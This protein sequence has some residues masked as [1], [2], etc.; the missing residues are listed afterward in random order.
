MNFIF[1]IEQ[2][3]IENI[4]LFEKKKNV[5]IDGNFTK[6]IY[7]DDLITMNGIYLNFPIEIQNNTKHYSNKNI[8]FYPYHLKNIQYIKAFCR[9]EEYIIN[10]YKIFYDIDKKNHLGLAKQLYSGFFKVY[11]DKDDSKRLYKNKYILKISGIWENMSD[12]G[13]TYKLIE[14]YEI[15]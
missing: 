1:N 9:I 13:I 7:S 5:V 14:M 10:Y 12:V 4:H 15:T 6:I 11:A 3:Q 2:F 8:H